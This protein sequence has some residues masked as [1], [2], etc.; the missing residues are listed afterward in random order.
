MT[1]WYLRTCTSRIA[2]A[3][4]QLRISLLQ[5]VQTVKCLHHIFSGPQLFKVERGVSDGIPNVMS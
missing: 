2:A 4:N 3:E 1:L 5:V